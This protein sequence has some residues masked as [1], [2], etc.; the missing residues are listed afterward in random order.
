MMKYL[1]Y[2]LLLLPFSALAQDAEPVR[3]EV[4]L[5]VK[6]M[7]GKGIVYGKFVGF[8]GTTPNEFKAF[9]QFVKIAD[10]EEIMFYLDDDD[11]TM[12]AYAFWALAV[13]FPKEASFQYKELSSDDTEIQTMMGGCIINI[14]K[15]GSFRSSILK[16]PM[17]DLFKEESIL[18]LPGSNF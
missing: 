4:K 1:I 16:S 5:L 9:Q 10:K 2:L 15:V 14:D 11:P 7:G 13:R 8:A 3:K 12:R 6:Q 17:A 18:K